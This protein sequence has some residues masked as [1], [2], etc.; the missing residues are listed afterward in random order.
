MVFRI[1]SVR[2]DV[3][4]SKARCLSVDGWVR[5][6]PNCL[7]YRTDGAIYM[8][9]IWKEHCVVFYLRNRLANPFMFSVNLSSYFFSI[10]GQKFHE[11]DVMHTKVRYCEKHKGYLLF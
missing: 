9:G 7:S 6:F 8:R 11:D 10:L 4:S 1:Y 5:L 3:N 2:V